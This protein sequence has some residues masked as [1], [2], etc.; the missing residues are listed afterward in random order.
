MW[1]DLLLSGIGIA[2]TII[3]IPQLLDSIKGKSQ[4]NTL[5]SSITGCG[6]FLICF[7]DITLNLYIAAAVSLITGFVWLSFFGLAFRTKLNGELIK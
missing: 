2:F 4:I 7:V 1:Q 5:T 3:L 6:C